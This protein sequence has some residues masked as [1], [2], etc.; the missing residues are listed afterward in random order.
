MICVYLPP[1][2]AGQPKL[3]ARERDEAIQLVGLTG[4]DIAVTDRLADRWL[5]FLRE[6]GVECVD[7]RP[8]WRASKERFYWRA[9]SHINLAGQR[10]IADALLPLLEPR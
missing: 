8:T 10:A 3:L 1:P 2:L 4:E 9:D 7:L 6:R 5:A